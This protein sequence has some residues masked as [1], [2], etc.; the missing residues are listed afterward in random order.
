[1]ILLRI[2]PDQWHF[3]SAKT[4]IGAVPV[5]AVRCYEGIFRVNRLELGFGIP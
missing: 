2:D 4:K 1:M 5:N 3:K